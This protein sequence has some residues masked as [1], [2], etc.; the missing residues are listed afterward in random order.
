[1]SECTPC[2]PAV[3]TILP[4]CSQ[5]M[6]ESLTA[7]NAIRRAMMG[8]QKVAEVQFGDQRVKYEIG[9][10]TQKMVMDEIG[11]LYQSCPCPEAAAVLGLGGAGSLSV[12]CM[13]RGCGC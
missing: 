4:S 9:K 6:A 5:M 13:P 3:D 8:G 7:Y 10:D 2:T 11:R 1:M 12:G